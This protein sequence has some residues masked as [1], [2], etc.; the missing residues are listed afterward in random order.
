[1]NG[2]REYLA[3]GATRVGKLALLDSRMPAVRVVVRDRPGVVD[4]AADA[5]RRERLAELVSRHGRGGRDA[6]GELMPDVPSPGDL[7]G[8]HQARHLAE[9]VEQGGCVVATSLR[10]F[11]DRMQLR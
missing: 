5:C 4:G 6:H 8:K 1:M 9:A 2:Q 7:L 11:L 10:A 3:G